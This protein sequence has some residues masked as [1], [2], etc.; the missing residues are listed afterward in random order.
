[1][2]RALFDGVMTGDDA[3]LANK[4]ELERKL[5][6]DDIVPGMPEDQAIERALARLEHNQQ[7]NRQHKLWEKLALTLD[8]DTELSLYLTADRE[9]SIPFSD[10]TVNGVIIASRGVLSADISRCPIL[11]TDAYVDESIVR[12]FLPRLDLHEVAVKWPPMTT[13]S[14]T[15]ALDR[16]ISKSATSDL[17]LEEARRVIELEAAAA[18]G[19]PVGVITLMH[20]EKALRAAARPLPPNVR[21]AHYGAIT[22]LN[23]MSDVYTLLLIGRPEAAPYT[24]EKQARLLWRREV[25]SVE[26][27]YPK[28]Q[29]AAAVRHGSPVTV[30]GGYYHPD[31]SVE[32][33]RFGAS[34]GELSQATYRGRPLNRRPANPLKIVLATNVVLP[35]EIDLVTDWDG[36]QPTALELMLARG[37]VA[38]VG[39]ADMA[40]CY[41]DRNRGN[42]S[43]SPRPAP[44]VRSWPRTT[45]RSRVLPR[46]WWTVTWSCGSP[47]ALPTVLRYR[48]NATSSTSW[49]AGPA[50][51]GSRT[52]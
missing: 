28:R 33:L 29:R 6:L 4:L 31:P 16:V 17:V 20:I 18:G 30:E 50:A 19:R 32:A 2:P 1:M 7:V 37:G 43:L 24:L 3:R 49:R 52:R 46:C 26:S 15:Q 51:I 25:E 10:K 47:P 5:D 12:V 27:Y 38:P 22:G 8:G 21:L 11:H 39:Y 42:L 40:A 41:P 45:I 36:L 14:V 13:V 44:M 9:V 48:T 23:D 35:F 34:E